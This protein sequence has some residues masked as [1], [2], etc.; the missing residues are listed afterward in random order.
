MLKGNPIEDLY[1]SSSWLSPGI[2][3]NISIRDSHLTKSQNYRRL[4][5]VSK[6]NNTSG[7][8]EKIPSNLGTSAI[9]TQNSLET[10]NILS[11]IPRTLRPVEAQV[12]RDPETGRIL[13]VIHEPLKE[14]NPLNDPLNEI[15]NDEGDGREDTTT[16]HGIIRELEEQASLEVKKRPRQQ[17]ERETEWISDLVQRHGN[18]VMAMVRDKK[19]N[20]YQQTEGDLRRRVKRWREKKGG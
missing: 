12:Q 7:G 8:I 15:L 4:G 3:T 13:R 14:P 19:L 17:S 20:P 5:L 18:D 16:T 10:L 11:K 9:S 6:L 1:H 2:L